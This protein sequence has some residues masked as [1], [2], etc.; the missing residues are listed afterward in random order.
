MMEARWLFA[1]FTALTAA[2]V[3]ASYAAVRDRSLSQPIHAR[4][5]RVDFTTCE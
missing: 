3:V 5:H 1:V 2:G 4:R